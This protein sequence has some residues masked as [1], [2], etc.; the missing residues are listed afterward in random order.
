MM[1]VGAPLMRPHTR[2]HVT[3]KSGDQIYANLQQIIS[4]EFLIKINVRYFVLNIIIHK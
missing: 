2:S 3:C 1:E 4:L